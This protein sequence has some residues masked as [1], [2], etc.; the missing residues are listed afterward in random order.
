MSE[1]E[2]ELLVRDWAWVGNIC[3]SSDDSP[4]A[5]APGEIG[6]LG[7]VLINTPSLE[8][9]LRRLWGLASYRVCADGAAN[10][11][12]K[13]C[14]DLEPD[15]VLGDFDSADPDVLEVYR[16]RGV[17]VRD[18]SDDQETTDLEKALVA[19][20]EAGCDSV[21]VAGQFAGVEGRLDHTFGIA[22][23]LCINADLPIAVVG[24]E[25]FMF[26]LG[27]GEHHI[28]VPGASAAPHCGLVPLGCPCKSISTEGLR[29]NM[30]DAAMQF[31]G[32]VSTSNRVDADSKG[33]VRIKTSDPVLWMCN[34]PK[35]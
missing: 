11:L 31:G 12:L 2:A 23:A 17:E 34:L 25:C 10:R 26:F 20:R 35:L 29:W 33:R 7:L 6:K 9:R 27:R 8:V 30:S 1:R 19:V 14:E 5:K 32:L 24:D 13:T 22:N 3:S 16:R 18:L 28:L 15:L 21:V 4:T